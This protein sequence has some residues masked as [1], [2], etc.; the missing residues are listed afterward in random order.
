MR[1]AI[2]KIHLWLG[3]TGAVFLVILGVTGSIIAFEGDIDHWL[4]PG[5]WYVTPGPRKLPEADLIRNVEQRY[6]PARVAAV[7]I[8]R[9]ANLVR[10]MEM[11]DNAAVF[12][13]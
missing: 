13:N 4:H 2:L 12:V 8:F 7:E 6:A 1:K 5:I 9:Q 10:R 3:L 11:S